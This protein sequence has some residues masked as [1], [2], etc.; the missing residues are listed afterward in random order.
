[1]KIIKVSQDYG[2]YYSGE[3]P[4]YQGSYIGSSSVDISNISSQFGDAQKSVD[5]V[6]KFDSNLLKNIV[7]IFNFSKSGVY[8][9][10]VPALD[11][12]IKTQELGKRLVSKGYEIVEENGSL[13]AYPKNEEK[14]TATIKQEIQREYDDLMSKGG[15]AIGLN[16]ANT[17]SEAESSFNNIKNSVSQENLNSLKNDLMIAHVA[18]TMAHEATHARGAEDEGTP[19]HVE[20]TLLNLAMREIQKKYSIEGELS[21]KKGS[22]NDWYKQAQNHPFYPPSGSDLK[23]RHGHQGGEDL[24]GQAAWSM[25]NQQYSN[26]AIE[27]MLGRQFQ[28]PLPKDLSSEHD[29]YELQLRK[30]TRDDWKLDPKLIFEELLAKD[31][32]ED[33]TAYR[34]MEELLED[35]RPKPLMMTLKQASKIVKEATLFGWFNNLEISDGST[36]PGMGDRVMAW[37]DRDESFSEEEDWIKSQPRYNPSYDLKG[38]YYRWIEPRFK[39]ETWFDFTRDFGNTH[40]AKRFASSNDLE[41]IINTLRKIRTKILNGDPRATRFICSEDMLCVVDKAMSGCKLEMDVFVLGEV[42]GEEV[43]SCWIHNG[44]GRKKINKVERAIKKNNENLREMLKEI[45]GCDSTLAQVVKEIMNLAKDISLEYEI[46]DIYAIGAY[47]REIS[48]GDRTPEVEELEFTSNSP[49]SCFK[50]GYLLAEKLNIKPKV[51]KGNNCICFN[52]KGVSVRFNGGK[53]I[54]SIDKWMKNSKLDDNS[55]VMHDLYNKDFTINAQSYNPSSGMITSPFG[56][57][58]IIKTV[59]DADDVISMNPFIILRALYLSVRHN[60]DIDE[61]LEK[62]IDKY[63]PLLIKKYKKEKLQFAKAKIEEFGKEEAQKIFEKY[64]LSEILDFGE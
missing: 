55:N 34:T 18:A 53:R 5:L 40:P 30:Y 23:G 25:L 50:F 14:D 37:D 38:F 22:S 58:R 28:S 17:R 51:H 19:T 63:S 21:L 41:S 44:V 2:G 64:G 6:N 49:T 11:R 31:R 12:V 57:N 26:R 59:I 39:P 48:L 56:R 7:Y 1:M 62:A 46:Y 54:N 9:V 35:T 45:I 8:G 27:Q 3:A 33:N 42:N 16:I 43:Y 24:Q 10:Y 61:D 29:S 4:E 13:S 20:T 15:S 32:V 47:A 60:I 36:I 52:Y